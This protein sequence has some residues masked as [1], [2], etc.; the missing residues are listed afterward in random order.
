MVAGGAVCRDYFD[1]LIAA[2]DVAWNIAQAKDPPATDFRIDAENIHAAAGQLFDRKLVELR[3]DAGLDAPALEARFE[4]ILKFVRDRDTFFVLIQRDQLDL[5]WGREV[6]QLEDLRFVHRIFTTRPNT[7][8]WRGVDTVVYMVDIPALVKNRMRKVP[9]EFWK[10]GEMDRLRR[11]TWI[12]EPNWSRTSASVPH[13]HKDDPMSSDTEQ[14]QLDTSTGGGP[15]DDAA[16]D[17][18]NAGSRTE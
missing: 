15:F 6:I 14:L 7:G 3:A 13:P 16:T 11:A 2:A 12:Y 1:V 8:S 18:E 9:I 17:P 4:D 10:P 5:D